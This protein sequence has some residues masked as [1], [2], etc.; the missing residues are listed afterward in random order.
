MRTDDGGVDASIAVEPSGVTPVGLLGA[1]AEPVRWRLLS[2]LASGPRYVCDLQTVAR[3]TGPALSYHLKVLRAAGLITAV[4]RGR[5]I[6]YALA[7]DAAERMRA[8]LPIAGPADGPGSGAGRVA[9][10]PA[11]VDVCRNLDAVR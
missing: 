9:D 5:W 8:A 2:A 1:V 4:R 10:G 7:P 3:V 6:D 11:G